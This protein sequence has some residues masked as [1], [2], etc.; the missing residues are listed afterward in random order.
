MMFAVWRLIVAKAGIIESISGFIYTSQPCMKM[1]SNIAMENIIRSFEVL[2]GTLVLDYDEIT[3]KLWC[4]RHESEQWESFWYFLTLQSM[5][6]G[7][8]MVSRLMLV[9]VINFAQFNFMY[10]ALPRIYL[11]PLLVWCVLPTNLVVSSSFCLSKKRIEWNGSM[12]CSRRSQRLTH[13]RHINGE[14]CKCWSGWCLW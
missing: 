5:C 12:S 13:W 7:V 3:C 1:T 4:I 8:I 11:Y 14:I 9:Q 10:Y 2:Y 6:L